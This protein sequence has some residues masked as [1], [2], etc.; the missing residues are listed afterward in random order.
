MFRLVCV[1]SLLCLLAVEELHAGGPCRGNVVTQVVNPQQATFTVVPFAV[2]VAVPVAT[3]STPVTFYS[4]QHAAVVTPATTSTATV[5]PAAV[6]LTPETILSRHCAACHR[7]P[8][9]Q[10][11][12]T[13]FDTRGKLLDKLPRHVILDAVMADEQAPPRMPPPGSE[14][15]SSAELRV[16]RKWL[17]ASREVAF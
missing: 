5:Q 9:V 17:T 11:G 6:S 13:L 3:I 14:S 12:L 10:G 2:P 8:S 7:G 1:T 15:L 16:L 4:Y